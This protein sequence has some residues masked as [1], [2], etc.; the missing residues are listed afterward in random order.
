MVTET[1]KLL[2]KFCKKLQI[3]SFSPKFVIKDVHILVY[4]SLQK[5]P[6]SPD[7][8]KSSDESIASSF[9][10]HDPKKDRKFS[11]QRSFGFGRPSQAPSEVSVNLTPDRASNANLD[12][13]AVSSPVKF[14][15]FN[16]SSRSTLST[17]LI[18]AVMQDTYE[19]GGGGVSVLRRAVSGKTQNSS[20]NR[21]SWKICRETRSNKVKML[22]IFRYF[23]NLSQKIGMILQIFG[24]TFIY[25]CSAQTAFVRAARDSEV[26]L[27]RM[28]MTC[29]L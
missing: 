13:M 23:G 29:Y 16:L 24:R 28:L 12:E 19:G 25:T 27:C 9:V 26:S 1:I 11:K 21:E 2:T 10:A 6:K 5:S 4:S 20:G 17:L 15:F 18:L 14:T 7:R 22:G 3:C 8:R